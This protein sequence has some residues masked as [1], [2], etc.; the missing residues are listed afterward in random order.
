MFEL[1]KWLSS[2]AF[3]DGGEMVGLMAVHRADNGDF[4]DH[5]AHVRKPV[6]DRDSRLPVLFISA[7][8]GDDGTF[9]GRIVIAEAD[10]VHDFARVFIVLRIKGIDVAYAAAHE[11]IDDR[12]GW[13]L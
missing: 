11:Q 1:A 13:G 10:G 9:H 8:D 3:E 2:G 5:L 12:F 4:I 7:E 6:R